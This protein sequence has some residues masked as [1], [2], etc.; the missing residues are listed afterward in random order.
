MQAQKD[1]TTIF[2]LTA[3][4]ALCETGLG[5]FMHALHLPFTGFFVGAFAVLIICLIGW[6]SG[7]SFK[8][9]INATCLVLLAKA[10][11]SPQSPFPAYIAVGFQGLMGAII[12]SL[13]PYYRMGCVLLGVVAMIE[14]ALQQV[15]ITTLIFG[16]SL[17]DALDLFFTRILGEIHLPKGTSFSLWLVIIYV[18]I[19]AL[20][21]VVVGFWAARLP[22][23]ILKHEEE[24]MKKISATH[25]LQP[26]EQKRNKPYRKLLLYLIVLCAI[27]GLVWWQGSN[28]SKALYVVLRSIM[29]VIILIGLVS[30]LMK[31]LMAKLA[32]S[33]TNT[34]T[35]LQEIAATQPYLR[36]MLK[37]AYSLAKTEHKGLGR[38]SYFIVILIVI[39]LKGKLDE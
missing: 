38:Y 19:Y 5:G 34:N 22:V 21:G 7:F 15:L 2:R 11:V 33:K 8:S 37:P 18:V 30:P 16:K 17:F 25:P 29:V 12:F 1:T 9:L 23:A 20:W 32:A 14:S 35:Q 26:T 27:A 3:L 10:V 39:G 6:Y 31:W 36:S 4:W 28:A 24:I 13:L